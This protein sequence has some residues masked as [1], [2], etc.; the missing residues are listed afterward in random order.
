MQNFVQQIQT[1]L[2]KKQKPFQ[3]FFIEFLKFSSDL[4]PCEKK[5]ESPSIS[6][7]EIIDSERGGT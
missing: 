3:K 5:D 1:L 7:S 6:I 2:S 4:Q